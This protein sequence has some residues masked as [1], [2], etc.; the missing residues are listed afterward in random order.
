LE[1]AGIGNGRMTISTEGEVDLFTALPEI[2]DRLRAADSVGLFLDFDGTLAPIVPFPGEAELDPEIRPILDKLLRNPA[3]RVGI[4]TGRSLKD[5]QA[6]M[7]SLPGLFYAGNH[8]LEIERDGEY[9]RQPE[10]DALRPEL[11]C[12]CLQLGHA[13]GDVPGVEIEDKA[14]TL[15]VHY[16]RADAAMH[17][18]IARTVIENVDRFPSFLT[19]PGK[20]VVEVRPRLDV[21]KG[22]A[23]AYLVR[24]LLPASALPI[25]I[26]DD[27]SDEDA[28]AAIPAGITIRVGHAPDTH[29]QYMAADVSE[30]ARFLD[31]LAGTKANGPRATDRRVRKRS[32]VV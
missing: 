3:F 11:R 20:R 12:L 1:A 22:T 24:E 25:Y 17:D 18:W 14:I 7:G 10:A 26:G 28:F 19:K 4:V 2:E 31:W 29:A 32:A 13:I 21:S 23:V 6:R 16:R 27:V 30:V 5:V 8:G 15:S 9:W